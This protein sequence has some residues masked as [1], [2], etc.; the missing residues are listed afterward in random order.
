MRLAIFTD[1]F[2]PS[3]SGVATNVIEH[4]SG[5]LHRGHQVLVVAPH[6]EDDLPARLR[7]AK[8]IPTAVSLPYPGRRDKRIGLPTFLPALRAL[9]EF[10]PDVVHLYTERP[11]GIE[12]LFC[13]WR[14]RV[15]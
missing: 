13:A 4:A 2:H 14:L 5:F 6:V 7:G 10:G 15:P 12:G 3:F 8:V 11:V 9:R 1:S